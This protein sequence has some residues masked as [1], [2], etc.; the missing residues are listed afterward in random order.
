M[1]QRWRGLKG[2]GGM[3]AAPCGGGWVGAWHSVSGGS[4]PA[5]ARERRSR[6]GEDSGAPHGRVPS[7]TGEGRG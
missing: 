1:L 4:R 2:G 5:R 7:R 6:A 3:G